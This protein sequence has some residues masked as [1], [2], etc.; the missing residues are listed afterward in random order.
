MNHLPTV[1]ELHTRRRWT[2]WLIWTV[3]RTIFDSEWRKLTWQAASSRWPSTAV[4]CRPVG[5]SASFMSRLV[6][7]LGHGERAVDYRLYAF[8]LRW[9]SSLRVNGSIF[10]P[11]NSSGYF[12]RVSEYRK[13]RTSRK[14]RRVSIKAGQPK[15]WRLD[16]EVSKEERICESVL[17]HERVVRNGGRETGRACDGEV[18]LVL[19]GE[20]EWGWMSRG[21]R[22]GERESARDRYR[23]CYNGTH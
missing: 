4:T 5:W 17:V 16:A 6:K 15:S 1:D 10:V 8:N 7:S 3:E 18:E 12:C 2:K 21:E 11:F 9:K 19:K 20:R 13:G 14:G 23:C 22:G